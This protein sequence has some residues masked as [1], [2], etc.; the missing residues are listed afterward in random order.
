MYQAIVHAP[1]LRAGARLCLS[2]LRQTLVAR[3]RRPQAGDTLSLRFGVCCPA[4]GA[5][6]FTAIEDRMATVQ[7]AD[8]RWRLGRCP[9]DGG[10]EIPGLTAEDWFVVGR[11]STTVQ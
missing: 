11:I 7:I 4:L 1:A 6:I 2:D 3:P 5:G 9:S 8:A 10:I